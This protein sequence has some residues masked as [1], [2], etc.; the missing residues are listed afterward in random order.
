MW[1]FPIVNL[2]RGSIVFMKFFL[3]IL[4]ALLAIISCT[5]RR[6]TNVDQVQSVQ[7]SPEIDI[8]ESDSQTNEFSRACSS[9]LSPS[10]VAL[11]SSETGLEYFLLRKQMTAAAHLISVCINQH[12]FSGHCSPTEQGLVFAMI[13]IMFYSVFKDVKMS[14]QIFLSSRMQNRQSTILTG[15]F[16]FALIFPN[17]NSLFG[18]YLLND[19]LHGI[20]AVCNSSSTL[21]Q[22]MESSMIVIGFIN[23]ILSFAGLA[24]WNCFLN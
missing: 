20:E 10:Q 11:F 5:Q 2:D 13:G 24:F 8:I 23:L 4:S 19:E 18:L 3:L 1:L 12:I 17:I 21:V 22:N 6:K 14:L 15:I 16:L 7:S 9:V